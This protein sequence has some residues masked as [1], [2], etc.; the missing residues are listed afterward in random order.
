[1]DKRDLKN[2][3]DAIGVNVFGNYVK[4]SDI[5]K[6]FAEENYGN[7]FYTCFSNI[8]KELLKEVERCDRH[9]PEIRDLL[10][11]IVLLS[12]GAY[13]EGEDYHGL[14]YLSQRLSAEQKKFLYDIIN[15]EYVENIWDLETR[16][17]DLKK[18]LAWILRDLQ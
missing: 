11:K 12:S 5:L 1:M 18:N 2:H 17:I 15:D 13:A 14:D 6:I 7:K 10:N 16:L 4:K 3:L 8:K 9:I